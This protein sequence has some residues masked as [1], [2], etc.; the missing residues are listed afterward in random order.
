MACALQNATVR[1]IEAASWSSSLSTGNVTC[2]RPWLVMLEQDLDHTLRL[3]RN[4]RDRTLG[5]MEWH[6]RI[7]NSNRRDLALAKVACRH[8]L[9]VLGIER[10]RAADRVVP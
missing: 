10:G 6:D 1:S 9:Q 8:L 3:V 4:Q 2:I 7:E 5:L